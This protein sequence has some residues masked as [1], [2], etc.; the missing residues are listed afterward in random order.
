M[1]VQIL[2]STYN[3]ERYLGA[4]LDSILAQTYQDWNLLIRDDGSSDCTMSV[5]QDYISKDSRITLLPSKENVGVISSFELL[6]KSSS[7]PYL[8]FCDQDDVWLPK[9]VDILYSCMLDEE[10]NFPG[11]PL[12][13]HS[14][15]L[16]VDADLNIIS[17]SF[18]EYSNINI[19]QHDFNFLGVKNY[20]TGCAMMIN[21]LAVNCSLPFLPE[22][23]MHDAWIALKVLKNGGEIRSL[24]QP[25][26]MY[27]QH[28]NNVVG[29]IEQKNV[30]KEKIVQIQS[31]VQ[32][33]RLQW[34]M[35]KQI[36]YGSVFKYLF[37]KI[38]TI[39][40]L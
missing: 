32:E 6:L 27:R 26:I 38:R 7:A 33:N 36:G 24:S 12:L 5:I 2:L 23:R 13:V 37:Y 10:R 31:V 3:G 20:V 15:L 39:L 21:R 1:N 35:L 11:K 17:N 19:A 16:V 9:K 28:A 25:T 18:W 34:R 22:T 29:A 4:L 40:S 30:F 14:D 8:L